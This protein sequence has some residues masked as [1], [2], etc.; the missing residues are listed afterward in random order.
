MERLIHSKAIPS[1]PHCNL[2][3]SSH[4]LVPRFVGVESSRKMA[5]SLASFRWV[6]LRV[7]SPSCSLQDPSLVSPE[8]REELSFSVDST[9]GLAPKPHLR[10]L[11]PLI[12][13]P[14][15]KVVNAGAVILLSAIL[16]TLL[17]PVVVSPAFA[18]FP[19]AA[20]TGVPAATSLLR[21]ELLSSA[22][23]G[24]LAGCL[25][26]H[27]IRSRPSCCLGSTFNWLL[28]DGKCCCWSPL[29]MWA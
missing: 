3:P 29:G 27:I 25:L 17:H 23:T 19:N 7:K 8:T 2:K 11:I 21:F 13:S 6:P 28:E 1:K 14:Q 12:Y 5:F 22:W 26:A 18:S 4:P 16:L 24:F 15:Q 10:R 9:D 20:K